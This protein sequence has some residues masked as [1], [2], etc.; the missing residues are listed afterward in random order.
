M[1]MKAVLEACGLGAHYTAF[2]T[3]GLAD[4]AA[5]AGMQRT[6]STGVML[7]LTKLGSRWAGDQG[8]LRR[9][10]PRRTRWIWG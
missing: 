8:P 3:A 7:K 10:A 1:S 2:E 5:L 4:A 6:D 9:H